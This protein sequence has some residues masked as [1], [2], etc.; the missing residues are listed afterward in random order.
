MT[1]S[2]L[3]ELENLLEKPIAS[4][5]DYESSLF[6]QLLEK[7]QGQVV[8]FGSGNLGRKCLAGLRSVG[9][10]PLAFADNNSDI[11][12]T[13]IEGIEVLSPETAALKYGQ[14][15]LFLIT[16]FNRENS[17]TLIQEQLHQLGCENVALCAVFFWRYP[18]GFLPHFYLD[19]PHKIY[20]QAEDVVAAFHLWQDEESKREY[21]KQIKWRILLES[22]GLLPSQEVQYFP[23]FTLSILKSEVFVDCGTFD[24]DTLK[25]LINFQGDSIKKVICF[26]PDPANVTNLKA[27]LSSLDN[28]LQ[29]KVIVHQNAT[30]KQREKL[31]FLAAGSEGSAISSQGNIEVDSIPLDEIL[32]DESPTFIKMDIEGAELDTLLG[33][34]KL[35]EKYTPI[36]AISTYHLQ[37]HLWRLPLL[38][39]KI[40]DDYSFFLIPHGQ[41][42]LESVFYAIPNSRLAA[43]V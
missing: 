30:G 40:C 31:R 32:A 36:L 15:A 39:K 34:K 5:I 11:W 17:I 3:L 21:L 18:Q 29:E 16:I 4:V 38:V 23:P 27:Y 25:T 37:N 8:L 2:L 43:S 41:N 22:D 35:I 28:K 42:G 20:E 19:L 7:S 26:E 13:E 1:S 14:N 12:N 6:D 10:E 33:A 24:G 9:V